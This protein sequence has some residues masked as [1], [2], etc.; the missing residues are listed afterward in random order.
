MASATPMDVTNFKDI[1]KDISV[2]EIGIWRRA[3]N[4]G[5]TYPRAL[6]RARHSYE[7]LNQKDNATEGGKPG[8]DGRR[9]GEENRCCGQLIEWN[10]GNDKCSKR[11]NVGI[12]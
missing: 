10:E 6:T 8:I 11:E 7:D 1:E 4:A 5:T 3:A 2:A 12:W 9:I